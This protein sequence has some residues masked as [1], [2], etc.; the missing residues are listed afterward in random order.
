MNAIFSIEKCIL[1]PSNGSIAFLY[2]TN[3]TITHTLTY[4]SAGAH[5]HKA[6]TTD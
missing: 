6:N 1:D 5:I 2:I 3:I 4:V